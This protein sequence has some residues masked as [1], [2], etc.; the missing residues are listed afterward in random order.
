MVFS[1]TRVRATLRRFSYCF[2]HH[3]TPLAASRSFSVNSGRSLEELQLD[4]SKEI[5]AL[6]EQAGMESLER[7]LSDK[8]MDHHDRWVQIAPPVPPDN[9]YKFVMDKEEI[10]QTLDAAMATFCLHVE[11]RI[12]A[13]VGKGFYTIGPWYV[14]EIGHSVIAFYSTCLTHAFHP[15]NLKW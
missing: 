9:G 13:L 15:R 10:L 6:P 14:W 3:V 4:F 5:A 11:S 7:F 2:R 12:A 1:Q 8:C